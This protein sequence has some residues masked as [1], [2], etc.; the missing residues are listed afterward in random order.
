MTDTTINPLMFDAT[1]SYAFR[2]Y[3]KALRWVDAGAADDDCVIKNTAGKVVW[4]GVATGADYTES[5]LIE[6]WWDG[7]DVTAL[8]SGVLYIE[9]G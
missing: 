9:L 7:I 6:R 2:V 8:D 4:E 3:V 1:G 5:S